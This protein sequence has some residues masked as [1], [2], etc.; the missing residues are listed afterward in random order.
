MIPF[1]CFVGMFRWVYCIIKFRMK[2][3]WYFLTL[4]NV[5]LQPKNPEII[6]LY[7]YSS[8]YDAL[9]YFCLCVIFHWLIL[10]SCC[11]FQFWFRIG[12]GKVQLKL[13][14]KCA[15]LWLSCQGLFFFTK[16]KTWVMVFS[17]YSSEYCLI[18][19]FL[20][21]LAAWYSVRS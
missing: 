10:S 6:S 15:G 17:L 20:V 11:C 9:I 19:F 12:I 1:W 21:K 3:F 7:N 5:R 8:V 13:S 4:S 2:I 14:R 18:Y 16:Q